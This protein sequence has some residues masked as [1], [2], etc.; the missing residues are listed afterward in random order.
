MSA[1]S[2]NNQSPKSNGR[3]MTR[4]SQTDDYKLVDW[5]HKREPKTTDTAASIFAEASTLLNISDLNIN[6][7][8][9]R[10][11]AFA[12]SLPKPP[13]PEKEF[14]ERVDRLEKGLSIFAHIQITGKATPSQ[15]AWL[16]DFRRELDLSGW[17]ES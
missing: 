1:E 17:L 8:Q 16:D 7:I 5:L 15:L 4:L 14:A 10:L 13:S 3:S 11:Q 6:H 12:A 9:G 2:D